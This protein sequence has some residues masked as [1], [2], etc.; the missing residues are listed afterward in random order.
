MTLTV[1]IEVVPAPARSERFGHLADSLIL[2]HTGWSLGFGVSLGLH[3]T[4]N[5]PKA[6]APH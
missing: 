4:E 3:I 1:G 2:A 6:L 5:A